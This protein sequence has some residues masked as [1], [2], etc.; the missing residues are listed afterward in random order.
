MTKTEMKYKAQDILFNRLSDTV[1]YVFENCTDEVGTVDEDEAGPCICHD[2]TKKE[3][4]EVF[5][6]MKGQMFRISKLFN[7]DIDSPKEIPIG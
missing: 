3:R 2:L 5:E 7:Y 4:D 1:G 6:A